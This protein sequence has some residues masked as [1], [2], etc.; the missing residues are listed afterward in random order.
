MSIYS[1]IFDNT[2]PSS[3]ASK[4]RMKRFRFFL[5]ELSK[6]K[7]PIKILDIGGTQKFWEMM[8]FVNQVDVEIYLMNLEHQKIRHNNFISIKADATNLSEFESDSF[9]LVFSNSVIEHLYTFE[10][11]VKMADEI[12]RVGRNYFI[13]TPNCYFPIEPHF[14]FPFFQFL[15]RSLKI[16]LVSTLKLGHKAI[17]HKDKQMIEQKIDEIRLLSIRNMKDLFPNCKI[18]L[19]RFLGFNKSIVAYKIQ[20]NLG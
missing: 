7:K 11:Q 10:N 19:D 12:Q 2:N 1:F 4:W 17:D 5:S 8:D 20:A 14:T 16:Q 15:P 13:Q 9:D 3:L 18:Y 6:L